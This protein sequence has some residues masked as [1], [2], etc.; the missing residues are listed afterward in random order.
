[1]AISLGE[2][3]YEKSHDLSTSGNASRKMF[4]AWWQIKCA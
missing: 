4:R 3:L 2:D 1:L